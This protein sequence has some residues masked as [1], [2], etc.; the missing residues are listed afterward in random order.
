MYTLLLLTYVFICW[1]WPAVCLQASS[2]ADGE[3]SSALDGDQG[4]PV[5]IRPLGSA[6]IGTDNFQVPASLQR[7]QQPRGP[8]RTPHNNNVGR[9]LLA[10]GRVQ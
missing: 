9:S 8:F 6:P 7:R 4:S 10:I 2:G 3:G 1:C 5:R